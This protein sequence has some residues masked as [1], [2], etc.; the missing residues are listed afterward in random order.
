MAGFMDPVTQN[1]R[2]VTALIGSFSRQQK[3]YRSLCDIVHK[4]LSQ[5]VLTR[6]DVSSVMTLFEQKQNIL[7]AIEKERSENTDAVEAWQ[8][9]KNSQESPSQELESV[10]AEMQH[11]IKEFL[12]AED[13]VKRYLEHMV[14]KE[15]TSSS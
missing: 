5:L 9:K 8:Q 11:V 6:G 4:I 15:G 12:D 7:A 14:H 10:L 3:L 13:Q 2:T 1:H